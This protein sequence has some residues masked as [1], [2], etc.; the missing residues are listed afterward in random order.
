MKKIIFILSILI[1]IPII[2][3]SDGLHTAYETVQ[4]PDPMIDNIEFSSGTL[5]PLFDKNTTEY[6]LNVSEDVAAVTVKVLVEDYI[7]EKLDENDA[8]LQINSTPLFTNTDSDEI[9]IDIFT[10]QNNIININLSIHDRT[11]RY[12]ITLHLQPVANETFHDAPEMVDDGTGDQTS[13][14]FDGKY[15]DDLENHPGCVKRGY[16][17]GNTGFITRVIIEENYNLIINTN[18]ATVP[19]GVEANL[20]G[21]VCSA[22][23]YTI[24]NE[25]TTKPIVVLVHGNLDSIN[26][27]EEFFVTDFAGDYALNSDT[28]ILDTEPG[29]KLAS[30]LIKNGFKTFAVDLRTD[31]VA[32]LNGFGAANING[33]DYSKTSL[34][35]STGWAVPIVQNLIKSILINYPSRKISIIAHSS[36]T[37]FAR[38]AV[39]RLFS[40][41]INEQA[42]AVN[43]L[44]RIKDIILLNAINHGYTDFSEPLACETDFSQSTQNICQIGFIELPATEFMKRING[45]RDK[46][47]T[48]CG[49]GQYA[50]NLEGYCQDNNIRYYSIMLDE[51]KTNKL[52]FDSITTIE[53]ASLNSPYCENIRLSTSAYDSS[54]FYGKGDEAYHYGGNRSDE[55]M[56]LII[57]KLTMK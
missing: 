26:A 2:A 4:F 45:T 35:Y 1:I 23:E 32:T 37:I 18:V 15:M 55:G 17:D 19:E 24:D 43:P 30:K 40:E 46:W 34:L 49:D 36:G 42:G 20:P 16:Y 9:P 39:R 10:Q 21:F 13:V 27:W 48:P 51:D 54:G 7:Q 8:I 56:E 22:K 47:T 3:C 12:T 44:P 28:I 50:F 41:Y 29:E 52:Y 6:T 57:E 5:Q 33:K 31:L 25:D 38:D 53:S 11:K 14:T